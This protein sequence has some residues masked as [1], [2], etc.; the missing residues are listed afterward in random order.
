MWTRRS[1]TPDEARFERT[2]SFGG[3]FDHSTWLSSADVVEGG[4]EKLIGSAT[5]QAIEYFVGL[6]AVELLLLPFGR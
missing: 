2:F 5:E 1:F 6:V 3:D 4:K